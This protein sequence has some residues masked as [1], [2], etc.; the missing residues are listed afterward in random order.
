MAVADPVA[1]PL[2]VGRA[3]ARPRLEHAAAFDIDWEFGGGK[4]RAAGAG[5]SADDV[6]K[7]EVRRTDRSCATTTTASRSRPGT[8]SGTAQEVHA[9]QHYEL[10]DWRRADADLNYRRFFAINTLAGLR[11]EDQAIFDATHD[12]VAAAGAHR[13]RRRAAD[14]PPRRAGRPEGLP[15]PAG[16]GV[17][18]PLDRRREDPR[19][20]RGPAGRRGRPPA[21]PATTPSPRWTSVL[22]DPAGEAALTALDTELTGSAVDYAELVRRLQARGHRRHPR[23]RGRP[24]GPG[25]RRAAR[26][27]HRAADRGA[28]RAAGELRRLPQLPARRPRAPGRDGRRRPRSAVPTWRRRWTRCTRSCRRPAPRR[29]TRF[30]QTSGPVMAKGVEDTAYYRWA[31]VRRAQRG[32]RRPGAVRQHRGGVPRG[33]GPPGRAHGRSR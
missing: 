33:A 32:R 31:A 13:R 6:E 10:V 1:S 12:L 3:A 18:Q 23:L 21:P 29:R 24:A 27:R 22:V 14:R 26:H 8:G 11:V 5:G 2:V 7:L 17:G 20:R 19:A 30:E 15:G 28:G 25:D 9:R 4:V 16:R